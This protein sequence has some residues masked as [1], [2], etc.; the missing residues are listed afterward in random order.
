MFVLYSLI[1][2][3]SLKKRKFFCAVI[4]FKAAFDKVWRVGLWEKLIR[5]QIKGKCLR[6]S[7]NMYNCCR[8][9][10]FYNHDFSEYF[11]CQNG[12]RQEENL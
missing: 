10:I 7:V 8:S 6:V 4:D 1:E 5:Y 2:L 9:R 11:P 12:V 3:S